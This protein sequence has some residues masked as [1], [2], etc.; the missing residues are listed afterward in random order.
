MGRDTEITI[1]PFAYRTLSGIAIP[2]VI[3]IAPEGMPTPVRIVISR[4][5]LNAP[6][7]RGLFSR[8]SAN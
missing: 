4:V 6:L 3:E 5:E 2:H 8:S 7:D 1:T